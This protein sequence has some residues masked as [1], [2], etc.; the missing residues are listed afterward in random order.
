MFEDDKPRKPRKRRG[1]DPE[2]DALVDELAE[3]TGDPLFAPVGR[4][5]GKAAGPG[6][7]V[8][9][10]LDEAKAHVRGIRPPAGTSGA[11]VEKERVVVAREDDRKRET[12]SAALRASRDASRRELESAKKEEAARSGTGRAALETAAARSGKRGVL[13]GGAALVAAVSVGAGFFLGR[14][15]DAESPA[16]STVSLTPTP[17]SSTSA[18]PGA[19]QASE[20]APAVSAAPTS[21]PAQPPTSPSAAV[22]KSG[23]TAVPTERPAG[24][25]RSAGAPLRAE[26]PSR[27][28]PKHPSTVGASKPKVEKTPEF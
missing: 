28:V 18:S 9:G 7:I 2:L 1:E 26:G 20:P 14:V 22:A 24:T 3:E 21:A 23:A 8:A 15:R 25:V 5:A 6:V 10:G 13:L 19:A 16:V 11:K 27:D 4:G 12:I 17:I